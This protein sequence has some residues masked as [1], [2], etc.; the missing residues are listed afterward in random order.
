MIVG[1]WMGLKIHKSHMKDQNV[2]STMHTPYTNQ[3]LLWQGPVLC[4]WLISM[5]KL[6]SMAMPGAISIPVP[7]QELP[8]GMLCEIGTFNVTQSTNSIEY[9]I[10]CEICM[11]WNTTK[12]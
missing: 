7:L 12:D 11:S 8:T 1:I 4:I 10:N 3:G 6:M 9:K 5:Q 2:S